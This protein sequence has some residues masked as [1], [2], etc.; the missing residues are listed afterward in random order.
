MKSSFFRSLSYF[1]HTVSTDNMVCKS[2]HSELFA[3]LSHHS[4]NH[5]FQIYMKSRNVWRTCHHIWVS[6]LIQRQRLYQNHHQ[7]VINKSA[8]F[9][10]TEPYSHFDHCN[11]CHHL[12]CRSIWKHHGGT[13]SCTLRYSRSE[14]V[15]YNLGQS[16]RT[17]QA[18]QI[19]I[20]LLLLYSFWQSLKACTLNSVVRTST[21]N[22]YCGRHRGIRFPQ[23][24]KSR[25]GETQYTL[26]KDRRTNG[27]AIWTQLRL[28]GS[29]SWQ[30]I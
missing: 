11:H 16:L 21:R 6:L 14:R 4:R 18:S 29:K 26:H 8:D 15:K 25:H 9:L 17:F 3:P 5:A 23:V 7:V 13:S 20:Y 27:V 19:S 1:R 24:K 10:V 28:C 30:C 12:L 2:A 22:A